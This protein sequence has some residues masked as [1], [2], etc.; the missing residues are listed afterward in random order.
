[1]ERKHEVQQLNALC[2][3]RVKEKA[4]FSHFREDALWYKTFDGWLF[5]IPVEDT[6]NAQGS[7]PTFGAEEKGILLMRWI[8]RHMERELEQARE[9][10]SARE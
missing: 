5:P 3:D 1:M 8:R 2:R 6:K 4:V 7:Q 10:A 9:I